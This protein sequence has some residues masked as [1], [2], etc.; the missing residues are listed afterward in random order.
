MLEKP[1]FDCSKLGTFYDCG[2][3]EDENE[4]GG[5]ELSES[6]DGHS[7]ATRAD[8]QGSALDAHDNLAV[9]ISKEALVHSDIRLA[10]ALVYSE[11]Y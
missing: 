1:E 3:A 9:E 5:E 6:K 10:D 4:K 8:E 2:C 11:S 7:A